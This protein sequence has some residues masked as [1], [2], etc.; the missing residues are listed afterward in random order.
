MDYLALVTKT[1]DG[2]AGNVPELQT[3]LATEDTLDA[4][5]TTLA[6]AVALYLLDAPN[7][8]APVA[9]RLSD[10]SELVQEDYA[11]LDVTLLR[12]TPAPVNPVSLQVAR[13]IDESGLSYRELARRL[14]TGHAALFR[15]ANPFYWGHSLA[16]LRRLAEALG[17]HLDVNLTSNV[18]RPVAPGEAQAV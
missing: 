18:G 7:A 14:G 15:L 10:L 17:A 5:K 3:I 6:E 12:V 2:Y 13:V 1:A 4:L 11:E 8:P 16:M 9:Q